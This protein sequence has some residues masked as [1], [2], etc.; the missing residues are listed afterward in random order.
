MYAGTC[1]CVCVRV[2]VCVCARVFVDVCMCV[3]VCVAPAGYD[4]CA[5]M[6]V[7][8]SEAHARHIKRIA[9]AHSL[10]QSRC[11]HIHAHRC[12]HTCAHTHTNR[13]RDA[14]APARSHTNTHT[15]THTQTHNTAQHTPAHAAIGPLYQARSQASS[16][17]PPPDIGAQCPE[18]CCL[19]ASVKRQYVRRNRAS[20]S[21]SPAYSAAISRMVR[22]ARWNGPVAFLLL[23]PIVCGAYL[24]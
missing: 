13:T 2:Y 7:Q 20:R 12:T 3:C 1:V 14:R 9:R 11:V 24:S 8:V 6:H 10:T 4:A 15:L 16:S 5:R 19:P 18:T 17:S 22:G 21:L 23:S